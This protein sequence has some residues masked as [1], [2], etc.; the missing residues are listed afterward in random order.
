MQKTTMKFWLISRNILSITL[1]SAIVLIASTTVNAGAGD[2]D[3]SFD[4]GAIVHSS[5]GGSVYSVVTQPDGKVLVGGYFTSINGIE[6]KLVAR[7]NPDSSLDL[8]FNS[9]LESGPSS[10]IIYAMALQPDGKLIVAGS[11][12]IDG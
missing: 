4:A 5:G 1:F 9:T 8:S 2:V 3:L 11:F 6:R 12:L 7:L 10:G